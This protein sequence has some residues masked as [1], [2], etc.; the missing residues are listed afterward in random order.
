MNIF[1]LILFWISAYWVS[2]SIYKECFPGP[3]FELCGES[4]NTAIFSSASESIKSVIPCVP[5]FQ[6]HSETQSV[7][8]DRYFLW[9]TRDGATV[10]KANRWRCYPDLPH[11]SVPKTF[12]R[13]QQC[14]LINN[15]FYISCERNSLKLN[16]SCIYLKG[17]KSINN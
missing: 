6:L 13:T 11:L 7:S 16:G 15:I 17:L 9:L 3:L 5:S 1:A 4:S 14:G 2:N 8:S 12:I 10:F